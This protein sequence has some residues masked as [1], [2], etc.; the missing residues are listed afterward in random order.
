[1]AQKT[2]AFSKEIFIHK[3]DT[4]KYRLLLPKDFSESKQYPIVLFLHGAGERGSDN[5]KQLTHGSKLFA[6]PEVLFL[7][8]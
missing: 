6:D 5:T 3:N 7:L 8:L 1:M 4:L 2:E